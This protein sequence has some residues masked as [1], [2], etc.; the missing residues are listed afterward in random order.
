MKFLITIY[1]E[2]GNW[3]DAP[4]E[5]MQAG[6]KAWGDFTQE[7]VDSGAMIAGDGL[8]PSSTAKT[9]RGFGEGEVAVSDGP[10]VAGKEQLGGFYVIDVADPDAALEWARRIPTMGGSVEVRPVMDYEAAGF[11]D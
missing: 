2:E 3:E 4:P 6:L 7:L 8:A 11:G 10:A 5:Q 1:G 9:L